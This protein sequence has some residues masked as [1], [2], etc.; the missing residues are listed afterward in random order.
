MGEVGFTKEAFDI[1]KSID[2]M[3]T[4]TTGAIVAFF[5]IVKR[6]SKSKEGAID[7][8]LISVD[9]SEAEEQLKKITEEV[10]EENG[11]IDL[12]VLYRVGKVDVL[13][14]MTLVIATSSHRKEAFRGAKAMLSRLGEIPVT[15]TEVLKE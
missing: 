3:K 15:K 6:D 4:E 1:R 13:D 11:L 8:L 2:K 5:G 9:G 10:I 7:H 14:P 12:T